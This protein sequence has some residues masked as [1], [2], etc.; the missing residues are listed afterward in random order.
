L[1]LQKFQL[2][3]DEWLSFPIDYRCEDDGCF[4][5]LG[6]YLEIL[7]P[8]LLSSCETGVKGGGI[9]RGKKTHLFV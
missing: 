2:W 7:N 4:L 8:N 1:F 9:E 5:A 6:S 3:T